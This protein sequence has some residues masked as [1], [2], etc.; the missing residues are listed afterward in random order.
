MTK[1]VE[2]ARREM[3]SPSSEPAQEAFWKGEA[4]GVSGIVRR[5]GRLR[6]IGYCAGAIEDASLVEDYGSIGRTY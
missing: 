4:E 2:Q 1:S 6:Q 3:G 5:I